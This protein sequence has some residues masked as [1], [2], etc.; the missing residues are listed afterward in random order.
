V[1]VAFRSIPICLRYRKRSAETRP[2]WNIG[3]FF[4]DELH[5]AAD[6]V[7]L[8]LEIV[9]APS[10]EGERRDLLMP[11]ISAILL[12]MVRGSVVDPIG[13]MQPSLAQAS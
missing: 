13:K 7:K 9:D 11:L 3:D 10:V 12:A 6:G 8:A 1:Y 2:N 5:V 4:A